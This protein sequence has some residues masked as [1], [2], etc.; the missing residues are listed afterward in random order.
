M[1]SM[2]LDLINV[3]KIDD[4]FPISYIF[5]AVQG[6]SK[7]IKASKQRSLICFYFCYFLL[8]YF[9]LMYLRKKCIKFRA[10]CWTNFIFCFISFLRA[11]SWFY[12]R[13]YTFCLFYMYILFFLFIYKPAVCL[14]WE[15]SLMFYFHASILIYK[16]MFML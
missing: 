4:F 14:F 6:S 10:T 1:P 15:M 3:C 9:L 16:L 11:V 7:N 12:V 2:Q 5:I 13:E 8:K